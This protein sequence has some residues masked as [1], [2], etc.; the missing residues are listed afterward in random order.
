VAT[1]YTLS[2]TLIVG[3]TDDNADDRTSC[4]HSCFI[5]FIQT[6]TDGSTALPPRHYVAQAAG[7]RRTICLCPRLQSPIAPI[8]DGF[9]AVHIVPP[10]DS[11]IF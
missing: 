11:T 7:V 10:G 4:R 5:V 3:N 2:L 6:E 9:L 1:G 8:Q